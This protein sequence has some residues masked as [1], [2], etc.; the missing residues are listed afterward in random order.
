MVNVAART[1][2]GLPELLSERARAASPRRLGLD[3]ALGAA[4]AVAVALWRP[5]AWTSLLCA[6]L[7]FVAFGAWGMADRRLR[8]AAVRD[9][10][11]LDR[12][13]RAAPRDVPLWRA[14]RGTATLLGVLAGAGLVITTVFG[15]LGTWIS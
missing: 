13:L 12:A 5:A 9:A 1:D 8:A 2:A 6:A 14:L 10:D 11:P 4:A 3:V 7:C 15:L